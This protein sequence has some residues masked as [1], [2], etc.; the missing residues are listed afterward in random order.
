[1]N[2]DRSRSNMEKSKEGIEGL[3]QVTEND[4]NNEKQ[5][6]LKPVITK[7]DSAEKEEQ[8]FTEEELAKLRN[9]MSLGFKKQDTTSEMLLA[10][11]EQN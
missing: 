5:T 2:Q 7:Q 10:Q 8:E 11:E 1:M 9:V 4:N 6:L 3:Q